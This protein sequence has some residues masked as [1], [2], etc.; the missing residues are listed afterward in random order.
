MTAPL[1]FTHYAT[2]PWFNMAFDE[3][4][5]ARAERTPGFAAVRL[6]SWQPG[7]I[8][9]GVNQKESKAYRAEQLGDTP[10][11]RRG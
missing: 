3:W 7:A 9:Y 5:L 8:T 4:L 2:A 11:I 6:Y 1:F 10:V